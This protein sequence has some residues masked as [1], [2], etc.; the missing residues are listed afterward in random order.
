MT[1]FCNH[2]I[3]SRIE[4][5][6][7]FVCLLLLYLKT[8][9]LFTSHSIVIRYPNRQVFVLQIG[10][11]Q[12]RKDCRKAKHEYRNDVKQK[13]KK[14]KAMPVHFPKESVLRK[15]EICLQLGRDERKF[16]NFT[17]KMHYCGTDPTNF[18]G[19]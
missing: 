10:N 19:V 5:T 1:K 15:W 9:C 13:K 7:H 16:V 18:H 3:W 12:D 14:M 17:L 6:W 11:N 8:L 4:A 2:A